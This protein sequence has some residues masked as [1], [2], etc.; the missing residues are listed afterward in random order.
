MIEKIENRTIV[1]E[2]FLRCPM[3]GAKGALLYCG[4]KD[5]IFSTKGVWNLRRCESA[6]CKIIWLD[7]IPLEGEVPKAY[8][9]YFTHYL[10][11]NSSKRRYQGIPDYIKR[12][13]WSR[14]YGYFDG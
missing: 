11:R 4:L 7:P 9:N 8:K 13:Y 5:R 3:C 6:S 14:K 2:A 10:V 12:G 1:T